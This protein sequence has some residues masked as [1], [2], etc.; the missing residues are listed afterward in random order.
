MRKIV[1]RVLIM[2]VFTLCFASL[3]YAG[4]STVIFNGGSG[5]IFIVTSA[6]GISLDNFGV[7]SGGDFSAK[8]QL[9]TSSPTVIVR[10]GQYSGGGSI[11]VFTKTTDPEA[12]FGTY[13][14]SDETGYLGE[15]VIHG[16]SVEFLA[17]AHGSGQGT[18][19]I[20]AYCPQRLDFGFGLFFDYSAMSVFANASPFDISWITMFDE[21]VDV[22]GTAQA[23]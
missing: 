16:S 15:S 2:V 14:A 9:S 21:S 3:A 22:S 18:L 12:L 23:S 10:E 8:Q 11:T 7:T 5:S 20:I 19:E 17:E 4:S 1:V 13:L 6:P